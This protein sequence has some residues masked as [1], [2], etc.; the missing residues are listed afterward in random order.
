MVNFR[1]ILGGRLLGL[2]AVAALVSGCTDEKRSTDVPGGGA[3]KIVKGL[4]FEQGS[5]YDFG[6]VELNSSNEV[7]IYLKNSNDV[8]ANNISVQAENLVAP[9]AFKGGSFPGE[10]GDCSE[11]LTAGAE[12]SIVLDYSPATEGLH[13]ADLSVSYEVSSATSDLTL[14]LRGSSGEADLGFDVGSSHTFNLVNIGE[15][16]SSEFTIT[17]NGALTASFL[18][19]SNIS[20]APFSYKGGSYPGTGGTC[21][22]TLAPEASCTV[23]V[24]FSPM[25]SG[26]FHGSIGLVWLS[27]KGVGLASIAL[28]GTSADGANLLFEEGSS[29]SFGGALVNSVSTK[30][31]TLTNIGASVAQSV[32]DDTNIS[33]PFR[34][35]GGSYPGTSGTCG[36][37]IASGAS[38]VLAVEYAPTSVGTYSSTVGVS[39]DSAG[40]LKTVEISLEG[41]ALPMAPNPISNLSV[42]GIGIDQLDISWSAPAN[43]GTAITDYF[44]EYKE[45]ASATWLTYTD[46]VGISTTVL[47]SGLIAATS[48]D[49]RVRSTNGA[50]SAY[51]NTATGETAVDDPFF[52]AGYK[53]MNL[54]QAIQSS[55]VALN[56][57]TTVNLNGVF[58][59]TLNAGETWVFAS[60]QVAPSI[61]VIDA[62]KPI[63]VAGR[64]GSGT[65]TYKA[66]IVWNTPD[67]AGKEFIFTGTRDNPHEV[68]VYAFEE[69]TVTLKKGAATIASQVIGEGST[70]VFSVAADGGF[71]VTSTGLIVAYK[72]SAGG[73][74]SSDPIP[75]LPASNDIIGVPSSVGKVTTLAPT[76]SFNYFHSNSVTGSGSVALG[77]TTDIVP[78][79]TSS[80]YEAMAVRITSSEKLVANSNADADGL[81]SAPFLPSAMMKRRYAINVMAEWVAFASLEPGSITV[82]DPADPGNPTSV[83][84]Q[85][86]GADPNA[87]YKARLTG[88]SAGHIF[89]STVPMA[90]WY[91][92][93]TDTGGALEDETILF[94]TDDDP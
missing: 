90:A 92:P 40:D 28:T 46:G 70:H 33:S 50:T 18:G 68:T 69:A 13:S 91:E 15:V 49:F 17:N 53:A 25:A 31:L 30:T 67:W 57:N 75:L 20:S 54:G 51:S 12:C 83:S 23:V 72:I 36:A 76:A 65:D 47:I 35:E 4:S 58:L 37:S 94:G 5:E 62:D 26:V 61:D 22:S 89:E 93:D 85:K 43:N 82:I 71:Q 77:A 56:D 21:Q 1:H 73:G 45:T 11:S 9:F 2:L 41:S 59:K 39:Y 86:S 14:G 27:D 79:G 74:K 80:Q 63:F 24:D 84:L 3:T 55:V 6:N 60:N 64:R 66:N 38:C 8:D 34:Y 19:D 10:G 88:L 78:Q 32:A 52:S 29:H 48:Y 7:I 16:D 44:V 87:P 42:T 81:C